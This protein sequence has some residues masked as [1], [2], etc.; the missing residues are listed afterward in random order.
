MVRVAE[1]QGWDEDGAFNDEETS[2]IE[3]RGVCEVSFVLEKKRVNQN[4]ATKAMAR[5]LDNKAGVVQL[6]IVKTPGENVKDKFQDEEWMRRHRE[7]IEEDKRLRMA[8]AET[9]A[10]PWFTEAEN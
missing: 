6:V 1:I 9:E 10:P 7:H 2:R 4:L 3:D 8:S 5:Q